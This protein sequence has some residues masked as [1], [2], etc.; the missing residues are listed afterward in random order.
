MKSNHLINESSPY[1][2]QHAHNPVDWYPWGNEALERA[3]K[4]DK[5]I[6]LSIG[7]STC[8]WC[9]VM[10]RESF[11]DQEIAT[12]MNEN[13]ICIKVD[14]EERPDVDQV[15]ME[16][17][18]IMGI[19]GGWPLNVFLTPQRKPFYG[20]TYFP[21]RGWKS[22]L[23]N[24]ISAYGSKR[25][26]L[27]ESAEKFTETLEYDSIMKYSAGDSAGFNAEVLEK[28]YANL[29]RSFDSTHGGTA[30]APKFPMPV[31]WA[32]LL[33]YGLVADR[34]EAQEHLYKTLDKM[35]L[36]G[37]Y[38]QV[39]GGFARYSTDERW[40]APHFEKMLY[41]NGQLV[42]LYS[43]AYRSNNAELY[44]K[45]VYGTIEWVEREMLLESGG[46]QSALDADSEGVEGK[47]YT[48]VDKD[49]EDTLG[50]SYDLAVKYYNTTAVG[51]WEGDMN[52]L[53]RALTDEEFCQQNEITLAQLQESINAIN[54]Q[55]LERR[56]T[57]IRPG[58]DTKVILGWNA[59][60]STGLLEAY[61]TFRE[62]RF[63]NLAKRNLEFM[64]SSMREDQK[65][66]H[67]HQK[68]IPGFIDDYALLIQALLKA[69][70]VTFEEE[71]LR[72]ATDL[73]RHV[74]TSFYDADNHFFFYTSRE[75][76]RLIADRKELFDNVIPSSNS[77][78][79]SNLLYIGLLLDDPEYLNAARLMVRKVS[80]LIEKEPRYMANWAGVYHDM[81]KRPGEVVVMGEGA[82]A[83]AVQ[84]QHQSKHTILT[85]GAE[86]TSDLPLVKGKEPI[87]GK[88]TIFVCQDKTC[89]L[90]VHTVEEA[91]EQINKMNQ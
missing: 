36:G 10:E 40:F 4:E 43:R 67:V 19:Q 82:A 47:F 20:G 65:L 50:S 35:A 32:Y 58:L 87:D 38:D 42:S 21:P 57:K 74:M 16:A 59:L 15:Y 89:Q 23:E 51:N 37:I 62:D 30:G 3:I 66:L 77:V 84:L 72:H 69:Y 73:L 5:P 68:Q 75:S 39:G 29:S 78:M 52:I 85:M 17:L 24:V 55:L 56:A 64:W 48:W 45:V 76:E 27:D 61:V 80:G 7:Y 70:Q 18:N 54:S 31:I 33:H 79:A 41:D 12:I 6:I 63:L 26:E 88:L 25:K 11:E 60:M 22:L 1:L 34:K 49:L 13:Y 14:R 53:H 46:I 9:H 71:Y 81:L 91:L 86:A 28:I 90:P 83:V 2:Q 8:H 44:K